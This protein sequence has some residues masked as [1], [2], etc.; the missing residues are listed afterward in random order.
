MG[1]EIHENCRRFVIAIVRLDQEEES[2]EKSGDIGIREI[3]VA[4][5]ILDLVIPFAESFTVAAA[6]GQS[7]KKLHDLTECRRP[8]RDEI[9]MIIAIGIPIIV[10]FRDD[11]LER[12]MGIGI[13]HF[14]VFN[15]DVEFFGFR[16]IF[17]G[18]I[19]LV[20]R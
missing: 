16:A 2:F 3:A 9:A 12:N 13:F 18:R 8:F 5:Q 15:G 17:G 14:H 7:V 20:R 19:V 1:K 11:Y 6:F 4:Y 10:G